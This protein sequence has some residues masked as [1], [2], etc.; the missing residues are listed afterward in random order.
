MARDIPDESAPVVCTALAANRFEFAVWPNRARTD[1]VVSSVRLQRNNADHTSLSFWN[2]G[3][4]TTEGKN[5]AIVQT[6]D[7]LTIVARL[8]GV[9]F[10]DVLRALDADARA[11]G[12]WFPP[13]TVGS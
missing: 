11:S 6:R 7:A 13:A 9:P 5:A 2:R 4:G 3:A 12:I 8:L 10:V 1:F